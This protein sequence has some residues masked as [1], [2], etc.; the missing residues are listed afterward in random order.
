[1]PEVREGDPNPPRAPVS[2]GFTVK[3]FRDRLDK[4]PSEQYTRVRVGEAFTRSLPKG[5]VPPD[6]VGRSARLAEED[7]VFQQLQAAV[8]VARAGLVRGKAPVRGELAAHFPK[9]PAVPSRDAV[10]TLDMLREAGFEPVVPSV[11]PRPRERSVAGARPPPDVQIPWA[12][13][14]VRVAKGDAPL[15]LQVHI[16]ADGRIDLRSTPGGAKP[17]WTLRGD[18]GTLSL[19]EAKASR[20]ALQ[21][22]QAR[23]QEVLLTPQAAPSLWAADGR[24]KAVLLLDPE[25][26]AAWRCVQWTFTVA[27]SPQV[28]LFRLAFRAPDPRHWID[29]DLPRDAD[30]SAPTS[31]A[32]V[33]VL[34][35]ELSQGN[36]DQAPAERFT[37]IAL[38]RKGAG[39]RGGRLEVEFSGPIEPQ[40]PE[41]MLDLPRA[42]EPSGVHATR[43]RRLEERMRARSASPS[44]R[45]GYVRTDSRAAASVPYSDVASLLD[46]FR[47]VGC[48]EILLEGEAPPSPPGEGEGWKLGDK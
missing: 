6:P 28:H 10:R 43:W 24:S 46:L 29:I 48:D 4:P 27:A 35:A 38:L 13:A 41:D 47:R 25:P 39:L 3:L 37:R 5:P 44:R 42:G 20:E 31:I 7:A 34:V 15:Y 32:D 12:D 33:T 16:A 40:P 2:P 23:L 45:V 8:E 22:L 36:L 9:G 21:V 1:V 17:E 14:D 18:L 26:T 30:P 19:G 11:L